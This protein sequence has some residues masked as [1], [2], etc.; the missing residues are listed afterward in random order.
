MLPARS[1]RAGGRF[2]AL[3]LSGGT[4]L[5][6]HEIGMAGFDPG[7]FHFRDL[8][9]PT[10]FVLVCPDNE[11]FSRGRAA[12][13]DPPLLDP[14]MNRLLDDAELTRQLG[15]PPFVFLEQIAA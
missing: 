8:F 15:N 3:R 10:D 11:V 13:V 14:V 4:A 9:E 5:R 2:V 12:R 7:V 1:V 6:N